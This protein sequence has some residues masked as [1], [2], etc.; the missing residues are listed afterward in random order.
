MMSASPIGYRR[1]KACAGYKTSGLQF[2]YFLKPAIRQ[3][4]CGLYIVKSYGYK[5]IKGEDRSPYGR[6]LSGWEVI[7]L[8]A[9]FI[10][11]MYREKGTA[12]CLF[13]KGPY[14]KAFVHDLYFLSI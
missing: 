9:F 13:E 10:M 8:H 14:H 5:I 2:G 3:N 6:I 1:V 11:T 7:S 12:F 4:S